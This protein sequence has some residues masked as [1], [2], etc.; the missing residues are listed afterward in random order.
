MVN[1]N[2]LIMAAVFAIT[3]V[4]ICNV[5]SAA[6]TVSVDKV[7]INGNYIGVPKVLNSEFPQV[8][9]SYDFFPDGT[10]T[11]FGTITNGDAKNPT[12]VTAEFGDV[13]HNA[14]N[15]SATY[16]VPAD[17]KVSFELTLAAS[18]SDDLGLITTENA[19]AS[20]KALNS[21]D[22]VN[23]PESQH[24]IDYGPMSNMVVIYTNGK[25]ES[26]SSLM[27]GLNQTSSD[28]NAYYSNGK[29]DFKNSPLYSFIE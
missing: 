29:F 3:L 10:Y 6:S 8:G 24:T 26:N 1:V 13:E 11:I 4:A 12:I 20:Y 2:R 7:Q 19:V 27:F 25:I 22:F 16:N 17:G 18:S 23:A 15:V 9:Y 5:A 21:D 14:A 28:L